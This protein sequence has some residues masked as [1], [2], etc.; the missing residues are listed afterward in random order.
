[1]YLL[2]SRKCIIYMKYYFASNNQF[3]Y[4]RSALLSVFHIKKSDSKRANFLRYCSKD[5]SYYLAV[6][7]ENSRQVKLCV[8][9]I[10]AL[11]HIKNTIGAVFN[12]PY[13]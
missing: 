10:N 1:M 6:D 11:R 13:A 12:R 2:S 7:T 9:Y 5:G 3:C 4:I 8:S